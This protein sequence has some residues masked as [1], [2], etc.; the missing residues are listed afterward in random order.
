MDPQLLIRFPQFDQVFFVFQSPVF[1]VPA[2]ASHRK[3]EQ[4]EQTADYWGVHLHIRRDPHQSWQ[5][6]VP[7]N[8][9]ASYI[10]SYIYIVPQLRNKGE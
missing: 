6:L 7:P 3:N 2:W 5:F 9:G 10:S 4:I 1:Q 8:V